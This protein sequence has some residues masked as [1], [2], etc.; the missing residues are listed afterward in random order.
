MEAVIGIPRALL[1]HHYHLLWESFFDLLEIKTITSPPTNKEILNMGV[2]LTV[3]EACLPV[4]IFFGHCNYLKEN[5]DYIFLPRMISGKKREYFCPKLMGISDMVNVGI[6]GLPEIIAPKIDLSKSDFNLYPALFETARKLKRSRVS[7]INAYNKAF[8]LW[9]KERETK[10]AESCVKPKLDPEAKLRIAVIGHSYNLYDDYMNLNLL[11]RL[12]AMNIDVVTPEILPSWAINKGL[13][14][15]K[16]RIYW[17]LGRRV[18]GATRFYHQYPGYVDGIILVVAF[19]C[20]P[21]SLIGELLEREIRK[22]NSLPL[23]LLTLDEHSG[24]AGLV[25]RI[26]AFADLIRRRDRV[27]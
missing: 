1:Y 17:S 26:E 24:E 10:V 7:T 15:L 23:L 20:G 19:G 9:R 25:T 21:D 6:K 18:M 3:D 14:G 2:S 12:T 4:K 22:T 16:K 5:T 27:G 8:K 11:D 13:D